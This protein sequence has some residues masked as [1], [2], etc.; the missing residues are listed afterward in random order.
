MKKV[1]AISLL[2]V[3][4][5]FLFSCSSKLESKN[6]II[7][8]KYQELADKTDDYLKS[9]NFTGSVLV[10]KGNKIL[11]AKGYGLTDEKNPDSEPI[12]IN[13]KLEIGS[14]T[15]QFTASAIMQL[16]E[17][18]L[19]SVNDK[20]SKYFP[21][22]IYGDKITIKNLLTMRS[23]INPSIYFSDELI[24]QGLELLEN[25]KP[26]DTDFWISSLNKGG[27]KHEPG[28]VHVYHN[29]NYVLLGKIVEQVSGMSYKDY[30]QKHFYNPCRMTNTNNDSGN[31][32]VKAYDSKGNEQYF[33]DQ[34][35]FACGDMNSTVVDLYKWIQ[36]L[37]KGKIVSRKSLFEMTYKRVKDSPGYGY[38]LM[39]NGSNIFHTG[40]TLNYNSIMSYDVKTKVTI[41]VLSNKSRHEKDTKSFAQYLKAFWN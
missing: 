10:A 4:S 15:K 5:F 24:S 1:L 37:V 13:S 32:D 22:Y 40:E 38:G 31:I 25:G 28:K 34:Y 36:K 19:L 21:D 3:S 35:S 30:V 2:F 29:I 17:K 12:N 20:I 14:I 23:G 7:D 8:S 41:I 6:E 9:V 11:F 16:E 33:P 18:K 26:L 27:M 39:Y